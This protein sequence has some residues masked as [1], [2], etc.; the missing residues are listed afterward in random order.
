MK[1]ISLLLLFLVLGALPVSAAPEKKL[2]HDIKISSIIITEESLRCSKEVLVLV[3]IVNK[4]AFPEDVYV[5]LINRPL[6]VHAFSP[7]VTIGPRSR[8]QVLIPLSFAEEPQGTYLFD[9]YLFTGSNIQATF[10]S[11][12]FAG[13]KTVKLASLLQEQPPLPLPQPA[14]PPSSQGRV[15]LLFVSTLLLATILVLLGCV[16][17]FRQF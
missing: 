6:G 5:E 1:S 8:E 11:F 4:G 7:I 15:D 3:D 17:L 13:C 12:T 16:A 9:A 10:Q 14:S 2:F